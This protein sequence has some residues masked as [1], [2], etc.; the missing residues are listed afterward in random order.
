MAVSAATTE[1]AVEW[2][3][4][5]TRQVPQSNL[6]PGHRLSGEGYGGFIQ[7]TLSCCNNVLSRPQPF[8]FLSYPSLWSPYHSCTQKYQH[9]ITSECIE[10]NSFMNLQI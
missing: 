2:L 9:I 4:F 3:P 1:R 7:S 6:G 5:G 8:H 10:Q